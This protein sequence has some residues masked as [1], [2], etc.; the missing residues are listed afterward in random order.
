MTAQTVQTSHVRHGQPNSLITYGITA[1]VI[2]VVM[3]L[4]WRRMSRVIPLKLERLWIVPAIYAVA[5]AATFAVTPPTGLGWLFCLIAL[6]LGAGLGWQRRRMM[7]ITVDPATHTLNQTGSP[8]AMLFLVALVV[9]RSGA[10]AALASGG[11]GLHVDA[12]AL[13]DM[14]MA[15][16]LG[17]FS[18]T[19][20]E[21]YLR[22]RRLLAGAKRGDA[23]PA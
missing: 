3:A 13:T 20:I 19:R 9:I 6:A 21:M 16:A 1:V 5:V 22:G 12:M 4:R 7:R 10:R 14:L 17:L 18:A 2:A 8:A 15:L 11:T 23:R